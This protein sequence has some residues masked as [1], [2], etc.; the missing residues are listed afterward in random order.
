MSLTV[1][2]LGNPAPQGSK[3]HVGNGIMIEVSK[4]VTPWR[5]AIKAAIWRQVNE[6]PLNEWM[7]DC[8]V[9]VEVVFTLNK[10]RTAPK[11]T[12]TW[13]SKRP[14]LDKLIRSTLDGITESGAIRNDAQVVRLVA[15]KV[16]PDDGYEALSTPGAWIRITEVTDTPESGSAA[17]SAPAS[18]N[19]GA[20]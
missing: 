6:V 18:G 7:H 14:D 2:V 1:T 5:E 10:P 4:N 17:V 12:R 20:T 9:A 19:R 3:R 16:Y 11:T 13:P 8:P 15:A